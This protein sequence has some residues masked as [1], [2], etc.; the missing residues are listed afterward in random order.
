MSENE[1][2]L[3]SLYRKADAR[4]KRIIISDAQFQAKESQI[5]TF[6]VPVIRGL[7]NHCNTNTKSDTV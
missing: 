3:L 1:K 2:Y 7:K 5:L 6:H 4:G